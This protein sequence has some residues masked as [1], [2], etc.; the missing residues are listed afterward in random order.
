MCIIYKMFGSHSS[1]VSQMHYMCPLLFDA[2]VEVGN[3]H[4]TGM[5]FILLLAGKFNLF[6]AEALDKVVHS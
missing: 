3:M 6:Y 1:Q 5:K 2:Q 4:K